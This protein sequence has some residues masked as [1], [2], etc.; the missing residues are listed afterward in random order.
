MPASLSTVKPTCIGSKMCD[1]SLSASLQSWLGHELEVRGIDAIIYTRYILSILQQDSF[2]LEHTD[3]T[4]FPLQR[5]DDATSLLWKGK[6]KGKKKSSTSKT[7]SETLKKN[8][9]VECLLSVTDEF[10]HHHVHTSRP[11]QSRL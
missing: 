6:A 5:K 10:K 4:Y 8:A 7:P 3:S 9:A 11:I 1:F 2:D